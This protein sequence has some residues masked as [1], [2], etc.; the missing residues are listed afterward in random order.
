[1]FGRERN[2]TFKAVEVKESFTNI[3]GQH[4]HSLSLSL[5]PSLSLS[6]MK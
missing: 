5:S 6:R 2:L 3:S 4:S 1:M